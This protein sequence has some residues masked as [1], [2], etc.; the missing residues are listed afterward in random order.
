LNLLATRRSR[1]VLFTSLYVSEGAP[2][3]FLWWALPT[4][5]R[6]N[7]VPLGEITALTSL[8][9]LPWALKFLWAPLIDLLRYRRPLKHWIILTQSVMGL[10]LLPLCFLD[11]ERQFLPISILLIVHSF[12]AATQDVSIDALCIRSAP[13][14]ERGTLNGWMQAGMLTSRALLGGGALVMIKSIGLPG[15]VILLVGVIWLS[16][17]LVIFTQSPAQSPDTSPGGFRKFRTT[18]Q[19]TIAKRSTWFGLLFAAIAGAG[20]EAVGA[21]AGPFLL[22]QGLDAETVGWFFLIPAVG[23]MII[24]SLVGGILADRSHRVRTVRRFLLMMAGSVLLLAGISFWNPPST[25]YFIAFLSILYFCIGL[26]VAG[27][28]ALFMDITDPDLGAT[29]FSAYMGA[30]NLCESWS[31][32]AVGKIAGG[33]GYAVAFFVMGLVSLTSLPLLDR[34]TEKRDASLEPVQ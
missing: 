8:L 29:Q 22:D 17:G 5:F 13:A 30:T 6:S 25:S 21:V 28:Y 7:G 32:F 18:L 23:A 15:I 20:Y 19:R 33:W 10:S 11:M 14:D 31:A 24:G 2:I 26:F 3:G 12:A 1:R 16:T 34:L 27:T 4:L 9:A